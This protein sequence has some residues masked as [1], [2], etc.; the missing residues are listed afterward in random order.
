MSAATRLRANV[1]GGSGGTR[2]NLTPG[3]SPLRQAQ[4]MLARRGEI[5]TG[6]TNFFSSVE[7]KLRPVVRV[8]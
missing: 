4:G 5:V 8:S 3:P 1:G 7:C 2:P 6:V